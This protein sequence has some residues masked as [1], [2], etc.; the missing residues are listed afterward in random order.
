MR[1]DDVIKKNPSF[2]KKNGIKFVMG[3]FIE[4]TVMFALND[5]DVWVNLPL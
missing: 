2:W 1:Q 5:M 3:N 4:N